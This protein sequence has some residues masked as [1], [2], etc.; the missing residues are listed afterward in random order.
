MRDIKKDKWRTS[1]NR[2][3]KILG[4][5]VLTNTGDYSNNVEAAFTYTYEK[6]I[7]WGAVEGVAR[8]LPTDVYENSKSSKLSLGPTGWG[9][10]INE[11][12]VEV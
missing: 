12:K 11:T 7:Y 2:D 8:G 1:Y 9:S 4:S 6:T 5:T 10:K 3:P